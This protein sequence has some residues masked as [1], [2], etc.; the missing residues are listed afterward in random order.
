MEADSLPDILVANSMNLIIYKYLAWVLL[1]AIRSFIF[2][3]IFV[4][5]EK[6]VNLYY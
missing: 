3:F 5:E 6:C 4:K 1:I 2:V